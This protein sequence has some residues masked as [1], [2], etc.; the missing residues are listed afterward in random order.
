MVSEPAV[1]LLALLTVVLVVI[2]DDEVK[3][4][5]VAQPNQVG[6]AASEAHAVQLMLAFV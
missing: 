2:L 1:Y 5:A 3:P 4:V 6:H